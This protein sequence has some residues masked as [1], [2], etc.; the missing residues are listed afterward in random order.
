MPLSDPAIKKA[1]AVEKPYKLTDEKGLYLLVNA[2]GKY[3]RMNYRF[4][5][6]Q[7]T[8]ALPGPAIKLLWDI[9]MQYNMHNNGALLSSW[10]YMSEKRGW[11]SSDSLNKAKTVLLEHDLLEQTVQGRMPN[12]ASWYGVTWLALDNIKGLEIATQSWPRGA[13]AHWK[14]K[15]TP[16]S[17]RKPPQ[18]KVASACP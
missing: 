13:Y 16:K 7:N 3:W 10:R 14:P 4:G 9:A 18:V 11:T 6:K 2:V 8:L 15:G 17:K 1:K 5:G 12:K